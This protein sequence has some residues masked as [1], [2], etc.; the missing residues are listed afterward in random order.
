VLQPTVAAALLFRHKA[1]HGHMASA[2]GFSGDDLTLTEKQAATVLSESST[3][4]SSMGMDETMS[5]RLG[6]QA[7]VLQQCSSKFC[8]RS[9]E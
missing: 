3:P 5:Q 9:N 2:G 7:Y 8:G 4:S 6:G 1:M